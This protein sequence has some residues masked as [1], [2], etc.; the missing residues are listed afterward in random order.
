V[1]GAYRFTFVYM[2]VITSIERRA[3]PTALL[4]VYHKDGIR[5]FAQALVD[6]GWGI[7][8]SGGTAKHLANKGIPVTDVS[9]IT[10]MPPMLDHRVVTLHPAVHGALMALRTDEHDADRKKY[11]IP[12]IDLL[13]VDLYP[14]EEEIAKPESTRQSVIDKTDVG[15]PS[16][17]HSAA[18]GRRIV[19]CDP[20]VCVPLIG[21]RPIGRM[22]MS[23][24][25]NSSLKQNLSVPST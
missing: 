6:L 9:E 12:W 13:W 16:L 20:H 3:M 17:L 7:L 25:R 8:S 2:G 11:N 10:G 18:K 21:L 19:I 1:S 5:D 23:L 22:R 24:L 14:L 4:S 15:G